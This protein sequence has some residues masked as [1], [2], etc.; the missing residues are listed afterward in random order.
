MENGISIADMHDH[1]F[2]DQPKISKKLMGQL[3]VQTVTYN[4]RLLLGITK[5]NDRNRV[6]YRFNNLLEFQYGLEWMICTWLRKFLNDTAA[7]GERVVSG[8]NMM[9]EQ[10]DQL[11]NCPESEYIDV[12]EEMIWLFSMDEPD[13][14]SITS[15]LIEEIPMQTER[16][17]PIKQKGPIPKSLVPH[18]R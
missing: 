15:G 14:R 12:Y 1:L 4:P 13:W 16:A 17:V 11:A 7:P 10:L 3:I 18:S 6:I 5:L 9:S 2:Y 8:P